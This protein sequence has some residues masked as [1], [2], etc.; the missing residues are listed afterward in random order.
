MLYK[1]KRCGFLCDQKNGLRRHLNRKLQCDAKL[2]NID[3]ETLK[4]ELERK[5]VKICVPVVET[6]V[7]VVETVVEKKKTQ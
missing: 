2:S 4:H 5:S 3:I 6:I 7:P 1:C